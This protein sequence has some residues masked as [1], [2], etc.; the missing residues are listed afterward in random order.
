M[1]RNYGLWG[2]IAG[3]CLLALLGV[4]SASNWLNGGTAER[5]A[6]RTT[7]LEG[8]RLEGSR[9]GDSTEGFT[10]S[11]GRGTRFD[12][13]QTNV[14]FSDQSDPRAEE[15]LAFTPLEE[16]GTYIQRQQRAARDA[17]VASTSVEAVPIA[18]NN[19]SPPT[20]AQPNTRVTQPAPTRVA[21]TQPSTPSSAAP[22]APAVPALW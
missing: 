16:A 17:T 19:A 3:I 4:R 9:S 10:S 2:A 18:N 11:E 14:R 13:T 1:A 20:P 15:S 12:R 21:D 5:E 22:S 6:D 8:D 7:A